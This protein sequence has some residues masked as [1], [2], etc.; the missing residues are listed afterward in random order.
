MA[1]GTEDTATTKATVR[2]FKITMGVLGQDITG[3]TA[4][5]GPTVITGE[6][7]VLDT[8]TSPTAAWPPGPASYNWSVQGSVLRWYTAQ[9]DSAQTYG[10]STNQSFI[11]LFWFDA[12]NHQQPNSATAEAISVMDNGVAEHTTIN[13]VKPVTTI[14]E[15]MTGVTAQTGTEIGPN[16]TV[17]N[18]VVI[19]MRSPNAIFGGP[20]GMQLTNPSPQMPTDGPVVTPTWLWAQTLSE[21]YVMVEANGTTHTAVFSGAYDGY[22]FPEPLIG[23]QYQDIPNLRAWGDSYQKLSAVSFNAS[24]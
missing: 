14:G 2:G 13:V 17:H 12:G 6:Q 16:N 23:S 8:E 5:N 18:F 11:S 20:N 19:G 21:H 7:V 10:L 22:Q 9:L 4:Q 1:D 24:T 3:D 15:T